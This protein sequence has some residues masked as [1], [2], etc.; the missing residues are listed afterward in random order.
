MRAVVEIPLYGSV[1]LKPVKEE[2][3]MEERIGRA[4]DSLQL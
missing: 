1:H 4:R 2:G 3:E